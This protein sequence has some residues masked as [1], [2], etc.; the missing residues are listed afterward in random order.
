MSRIKKK[1]HAVR[2][3]WSRDSRLR[4]AGRIHSVPPTGGLTVRVWL[5]RKRVRV[6]SGLDPGCGVG[7]RS[8]HSSQPS[9][10]PGHPNTGCGSDST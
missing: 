8:A 3:V 7:V 5:V 4:R 10:M 2:L 9:Y 1:T 6:R